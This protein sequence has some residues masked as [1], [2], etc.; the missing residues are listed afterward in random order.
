V[1]T[2]TRRTT[3]ESGA[4]IDL[5][6]REFER[7]LAA[8]GYPPGE[9]HHLWAAF[10]T[11]AAAPTSPTTSRRLGLGPETAVYLGLLLVVAASVSLL[12]IYWHGLGAGG[13][14][15][16][17]FVYLGAYL[18]ASELLRRRAMIQPADVL[19]AAAVAWVG[20]ATYAVLELT[21]MWPER[22]AGIAYVHSGITT[23]ALVGLVAAL[24]LLAVRPDPLLV[25]PIAAALGTLAT[26]LAE[27]VFGNDLG[28]RQR[29]IF[30]LPLGLMWL[31]TGLWLDVGGRRDYATWAHWAGLVT[32]GIALMA[33]VPK[34]V[35]GF[36]LIGVLGA[37][38]L[39]FSA[40]VRHWS[41]TVV[42]GI[43]VLLATMSAL[44]MLG[45][46]APLVIAIV[47]IALI[48][49]GLRWTRWREAIRDRVMSLL[50]AAA[51]AFVV[52][53]AP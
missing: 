4:H 7:V 53:L 34:T 23:I 51:R 24:A 45:G 25:V 40:F 39:F 11:G 1:T 18:L 31:G 33:L 16:V 36:A 43:G 38:S 14:L 10:A 17:A 26:D 2:T 30:L 29:V 28:D 5:D 21:G 12:A 32:T 27:F 46:V 22:A 8:D 19:E 50:P 49:T 13:V 42:G 35:P 52:R 3:L 37:L 47:G 20:L 48:F 9:I 44:G 6:E 15:A 41:F